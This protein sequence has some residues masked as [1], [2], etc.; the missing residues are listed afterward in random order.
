LKKIGSK[1]VSG[2]FEKGQ[3]KPNIIGGEL[4]LDEESSSQSRAHCKLIASPIFGHSRLQ[5]RP[6]LYS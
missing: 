3:K 5:K 1:L 6:R 2:L 4:A